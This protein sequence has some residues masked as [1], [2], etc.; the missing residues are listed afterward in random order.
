MCH[1]YTDDIQLKHIFD[2]CIPG[3]AAVAIFKLFYA[4]QWNTH[5]DDKKQIQTNWIINWFF[6]HCSFFSQYA[7]LGWH[8]W[9]LN[10]HRAWAQSTFTW[11]Q[12]YQNHLWLKIKVMIFCLAAKYLTSLTYIQGKF[13]VPRLH[14]SSE[15]LDSL[16]WL[17]IE[18][19]N[20]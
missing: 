18:K 17:P 2:P 6:F 13:Q 12:E 3:E 11:N 20:K 10:P 1:I 5:L 7:S 4:C 16:H 14:L 19:I 15:L 8:G 9:H